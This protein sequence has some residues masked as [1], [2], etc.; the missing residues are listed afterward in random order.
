MKLKTLV[1]DDEP[2]ALDKLCKYVDKV[3]FLELAGACHSGL[4]AIELLKIGRAHV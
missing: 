4:E 3:P 2:I 1:I